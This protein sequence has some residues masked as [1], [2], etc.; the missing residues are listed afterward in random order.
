MELLRVVNDLFGPWLARPARSARMKRSKFEHRVED[1]LVSDLGVKGIV[2]EIVLPVRVSHSLRKY[3]NS[4]KHADQP[5]TAYE[6]QTND[7]I[8]L[9]VDMGWLDGHG[10][11]RLVMVEVDGTQHALS[12]S[13]S[14][15]RS[16]LSL[17]GRRPGELHRA[18]KRDA[19]KHELLSTVQSRHPGSVAFLRIGP[20][21][22]RLSSQHALRSF[23][24]SNLGSATSL[25]ALTATCTPPL[26]LVSGGVEPCPP[27]TEAL[28]AVPLSPSSSPSRLRSRSRSVEADRISRAARD[29]VDIFLP[30]TTAAKLRTNFNRYCKERIEKEFTGEARAESLQ[31]IRERQI[32]ND[33]RKRPRDD[34]MFVY[35]PRWFRLAEKWSKGQE[36]H[37]AGPTAEP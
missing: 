27:L 36:R 22:E 19:V 34:A 9:R 3:M 26:C 14:Q 25:E 18:L 11:R 16:Q 12:S 4:P 21:F 31:L 13:Q 33:S 32:A 35:D 29:F 28:P 10:G 24:I 15:S 6:F 1:I 37:K 5:Y 17:F 30:V 2:H 23:L 8:E 20:E 7:R